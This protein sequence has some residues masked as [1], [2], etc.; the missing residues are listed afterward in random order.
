MK[1]RG[2]ALVTVLVIFTALII[3]GTSI[4]SAVIN[5]TKL[6]KRYSDNI[7]LELATKSALNF[8]KD[9]FISRVNNKEIKTLDNVKIYIGKVNSFSSNFSSNFNT[10]SEE[11][12]N[13]ESFFKE[14]LNNNILLDIKLS[15]DGS[16]KLEI[17]TSAKNKNNENLKKEQSQIIA[18]N[19]NS[20]NTGSGESGSG[21]SSLN[22]DLSGIINENVALIIANRN[23]VKALNHV[24]NGI[25]IVDEKKKYDNYNN[26]SSFHNNEKSITGNINIS[27]PQFGIESSTNT[28][29]IFY[30]TTDGIKYNF[31]SQKQD[32]YKITVDGKYKVN[33]NYNNFIVIQV[34]GNLLIEGKGNAQ[35]ISKN[36][37]YVVNGNVS[38]DSQND[39]LSMQQTAIMAKSIKNVGYKTIGFNSGLLITEEL[40][41]P[42][43]QLNPLNGGS[44]NALSIIDKIIKGQSID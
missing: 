19:F 37:I 42:N 20:S 32:Y 41:L 18:L 44:G 35:N 33:N 21:D 30:L 16:N 10:T 39:N 34:D 6:N 7:D 38:L 4:S 15:V 17:Q 8:I 40:Y 9:D 3:I 14:Y 43:G 31:D 1:K 23:S 12:K 11:F 29:N 27:I 2:A 13:I 24:N 22:G 28:S 26:S 25:I 5:T 36:I